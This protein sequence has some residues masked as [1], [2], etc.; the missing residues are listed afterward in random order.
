MQNTYSLKKLT[1]STLAG[2]TTYLLHGFK[3]NYLERTKLLSHFLGFAAIIVAVDIFHKKKRRENT[4]KIVE[5][6]EIANNSLIKLFVFSV[7]VN[8]F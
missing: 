2:I 6:K 8:F 7:Y 1:A 4:V 3:N 5:T